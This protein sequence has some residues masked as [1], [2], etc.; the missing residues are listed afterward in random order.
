VAHTH[1]VLVADAA[2]ARFFSTHALGQSLRFLRALD[3][4][5]GRAAGAALTSD[6]PGKKASDAGAGPHGLAPRNTPRRLEE[7]RFASTLADEL[8]HLCRDDAHASLVLVMGPRLLGLVRGALDDATRARVVLEIPERLTE[9]P[10]PELCER[11]HAAAAENSL[12]R[13]GA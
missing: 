10:V 1:Y 13:V 3:H 7:E 12:P 9:V 11:L 2:R 4:P 5:E 8:A 6:R